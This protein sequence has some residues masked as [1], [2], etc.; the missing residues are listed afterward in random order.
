MNRGR[1]KNARAPIG[2]LNADLKKNRKN[3]LTKNRGRK[4]LKRNDE[5]GKNEEC[6]SF[7]WTIKRCV[8]D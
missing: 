4:N 7:D 6:W 5:Q 1:T 8:G 2:R 3:D